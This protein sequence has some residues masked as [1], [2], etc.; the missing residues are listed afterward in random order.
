M[1]HGKPLPAVRRAFA[2]LSF[3]LLSI[4]A[5]AALA[6]GTSSAGEPPPRFSAT[7]GALERV[8]EEI[9]NGRLTS[10]P[11]SVAWLIAPDGACTGT[12]IGC[13]TLLS[14]AHCFCADDENGSNCQPSTQGTAF[15]QHAG[16]F[17][18]E[19]VAV[20]P[21]YEFGERSDLAVVR[22]GQQVENVE[23]A[24]LN[25]TARPSAG[26][27]GL[28]VG[29]GIDSESQNA[30]DGLKREGLV[31]LESC[32]QGISNATHL[33]WE[34]GPPFGAAGDD[35][36]TCAGDSGGPLFVD[37]GGGPLLAGVT[38]GGTGDCD[39]DDMAFDADVF[40]DRSWI[41][42]QAGADLGRTCG[43]LAPAG[44]AGSPIFAADGTLSASNDEETYVVDVP[45][46]VERLVVT[47]NGPESEDFDVFVAPP[48]QGVGCAS[49]SDGNIEDCVVES[50][51]PG[52]WRLS[53]TRF[54]GS[55]PYQVVA[56]LFG[57]GG[58]NGGE[59][60]VPGATTLC[61]DRQ[62]ADRRFR[63]QM[64]YDSVLGGGVSGDA[65]ATPLTSLG[66]SRGGIFA[67][68]NP[69]N[70][71]V[72]VKVLDGCALTDHYWVFY[73]ATTTLG[74]ELTVED[75][76]AGVSKTYTNPDQSPALTVTDTMA[77]AS[78][79]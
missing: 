42:Q 21:D 6:A 50:P 17:N 10:L 28:I 54:A 26:D 13:R 53:A 63:L 20:H 18:I 25:T 74:F 67:F 22:L 15:L 7:Q 29:F 1:I 78:C 52:E 69:A 56:T 11:P 48:G 32:S 64:T 40:L 77:L 58:G 73:A 75:T 5:L 46:G 61:I 62:P 68:T 24:A 43:D 16:S 12:L 47:L 30:I 51:D 55:G 4:A 14:A 27:L 59:T 44:S 37:L 79:P 34:F 33:C 35:S 23:P 60:C 31:G 71:E 38:S 66:I 19:S 70:P 41:A 57:S 72:L 8:S 65:A 9:A 2:R 45:A 76:Q 36:N 39:G 49:S 3:A